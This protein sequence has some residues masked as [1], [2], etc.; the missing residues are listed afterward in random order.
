MTRSTR[1]AS[2]LIEPGFF[3]AALGAPGLDSALF[4]ESV[5]SFGKVAQSAGGQVGQSAVF[6]VDHVGLTVLDITHPLPVAVR[7]AARN[8]DHHRI[9]RLLA[10]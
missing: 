2:D 1:S 4:L 5:D 9:L 8:T 6:Q 7:D 3:L 10:R